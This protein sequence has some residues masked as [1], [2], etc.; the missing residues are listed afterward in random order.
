[1]F[2]DCSFCHRFEEKLF[3]YKFAVVAVVHISNLRF[4]FLFFFFNVTLPIPGLFLTTFLV[5]ADVLLSS[6]TL[7]ANFLN[8]SKTLL[9]YR[10]QLKLYSE[11]TDR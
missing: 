6:V 5:K 3:S 4:F 11:Q 1:M 2:S 10:R 9:N 8:H 7:N